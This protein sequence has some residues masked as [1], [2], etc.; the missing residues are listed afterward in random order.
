[1]GQVVSNLRSRG[2][3]PMNITDSAPVEPRDE[4]LAVAQRSRS[5]RRPCWR[6]RGS[7][8]GACERLVK[9]PSPLDPAD[10]Q[11]H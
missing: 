2:C 10:D 9:R 4:T 11:C 5:H 8:N 3:D 1:M 6:W 7:I